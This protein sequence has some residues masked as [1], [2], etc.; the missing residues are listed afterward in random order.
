ME[1][2]D[3]RADSVPPGPHGSVFKYNLPSEHGERVIKTHRES[4]G[5]A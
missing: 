1:R 3:M 2:A 5:A 4:H